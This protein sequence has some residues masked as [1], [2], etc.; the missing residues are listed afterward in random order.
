M[1]V[2]GVGMDTIDVLAMAVKGK[3]RSTNL[4]PALTVAA[5]LVDGITRG[6]DTEETILGNSELLA[7]ASN[8][9]P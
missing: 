9:H 3:G 6:G 7:R 4:V 5:P 1:D 2:P 8:L